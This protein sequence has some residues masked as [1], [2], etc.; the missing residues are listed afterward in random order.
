MPEF[1][2]WLL[3]YIDTISKLWSEWVIDKDRTVMQFLA[4]MCSQLLL[5]AI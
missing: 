3:G 5:L 4:D 1:S 2:E